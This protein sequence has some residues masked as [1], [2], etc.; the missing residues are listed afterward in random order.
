M[1]NVPIAITSSNPGSGRL[2]QKGN[3][4]KHLAVPD[5]NIAGRLK[6][7]IENHFFLSSEKM[8]NLNSIGNSNRS[9]LKSVVTMN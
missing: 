7:P 9:Y 6:K 3:H 2:S 8:K 4:P 5:V 1:K